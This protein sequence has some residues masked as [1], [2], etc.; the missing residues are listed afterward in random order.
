MDDE[1][2][3]VAKQFL[4]KIYDVLS[5]MVIIASVNMYAMAVVPIIFYVIFKLFRF[6]IPSYREC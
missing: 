6:M 1:L 3:D 2:G 5:V 4:E